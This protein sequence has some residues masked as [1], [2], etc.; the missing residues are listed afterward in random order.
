MALQNG[1]LLV[2]LNGEYKVVCRPAVVMELTN[3][4]PSGQLQSCLGDIWV[5][6]FVRMMT[7]VERFYIHFLVCD[8]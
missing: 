7:E 5:C 8:R 1:G 3:L 2:K 4:L 6:S